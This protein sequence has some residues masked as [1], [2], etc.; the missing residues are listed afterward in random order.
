MLNR[1]TCPS[2]K[3][4]I[5][6]QGLPSPWVDAHVRGETRHEICNDS[7]LMAVLLALGFGCWPQSSLRCFCSSTWQCSSPSLLC[8][9]TRACWNHCVLWSQRNG[10]L[11]SEIKGMDL[12]QS[13]RFENSIEKQTSS[14]FS[15]MEIKANF[16]ILKKTVKRNQKLR[17]SV[18][19]MSF[20][21]QRANQI[22]TS[23]LLT[24]EIGMIESHFAGDTV[25]GV[26]KCKEAPF[27]STYLMVEL[28]CRVHSVCQS[29]SGTAEPLGKLMKEKS[30]GVKS[31]R[32]VFTLAYTDAHTDECVHLYVLVFKQ[33]VLSD[34]I[35][36]PQ[37]FECLLSFGSLER[38]EAVLLW[39]CSAW[40]RP[41][42][43]SEC[44]NVCTK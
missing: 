28:L 7:C 18:I 5:A 31:E 26:Q 13:K 21:V 25:F 27:C 33:S 43:V 41:G 34:C 39:L 8:L 6:V 9:L 12:I 36:A 15:R 14:G 1:G 16:L 2:G 23:G 32:F 37:P 4:W 20:W 11:C 3:M 35:F 29:L 30:F 38:V 19:E 22:K 17:L 42:S 10:Q 24:L 44:C 40:W